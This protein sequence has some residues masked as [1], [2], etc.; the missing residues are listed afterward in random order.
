MNTNELVAIKM[1]ETKKNEQLAFEAKVIKTM[2]GG[3]KPHPLLDLFQNGS[4]HSQV[5]LARGGSP[6]EPV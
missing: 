1:E 5:L 6:I 4:W 2:E 3:S